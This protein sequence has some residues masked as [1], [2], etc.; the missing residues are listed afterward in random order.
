MP[1]LPG[2]YFPKLRIWKRL[3][4]IGIMR[5]RFDRNINYMRIS[6][7]DQCNLR[8][9]YC[10]PYGT[11]TSDMTRESQILSYEEICQ[12]AQAALQI[13][14]TH[15]RITGGEPLVR[16]GITE[17]VSML[18][19][20]PGVDSVSMTTNGTLLS[21]YAGEL[22]RAGIDRINV[23]LDTVDRDTYRQITGA[24]CLKQVMDGIEEALK[25]GIFVQL[26]AVN[27]E[28]IDW[29][30]LIKFADANRIPLRFIEMMPIGHGKDYMGCNNDELK[31]K[32]DK[33]YGA[34][35]FVT[36]PGKG[37]AE[38]YRYEKLSAEIGFINGMHHKFC[39]QCNRVR[40]TCD[41]FL[42]S[43]LCYDTGVNLRSAL[44]RKESGCLA[45]MMKKVVFEKP[46]G[47][48]FDLPQNI[49]EKRDMVR[50]GG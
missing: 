22:E 32:I 20:L 45:E 40:L 2:M 14:I 26:N 50:I 29:Q 25:E 24:D 21:Q 10:M 43:C 1:V 41:G 8:C 49:T 12:V 4:V 6:V 11:D 30:S 47:H 3:V 38:Y 39:R 35:V 9:K 17:L 42:K 16:E 7:T 18:K 48:C 15:F 19:S 13:G 5:D 34:P 31:A 36:G 23:S 37:P 33:K 46:E 28:G 27:R 44:R